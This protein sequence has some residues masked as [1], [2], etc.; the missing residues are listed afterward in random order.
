MRKSN[1]NNNNAINRNEMTIAEVCKIKDKRVANPIDYKSV[2]MDEVCV[3]SIDDTSAINSQDDKMEDANSENDMSKKAKRRMTAMKKAKDAIDKKKPCKNFKKWWRNDEIC[4]FYKAMMVCGI[5]F[6]LIEAYMGYSRTQKQIKLRYTTE[7][8]QRPHLI[9]QVTK[10]R[11]KIDDE[12][13]KNIM[14]SIS[15]NVKE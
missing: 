9:D 2:F 13:F 6:S 15:Q 14:E 3:G 1:I 5:N 8:K 4:K 11:G 7:C 10:F 12:D